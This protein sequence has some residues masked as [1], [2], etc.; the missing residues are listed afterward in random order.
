MKKRFAFLIALAA[1]LIFAMMVGER[2]ITSAEKPKGVT[3]SSAFQWSV[4]VDTLGITRDSTYATSG[5]GKIFYFRGLE[6][7][8][9]LNA[10]IYV[11]VTSLDTAGD[12]GVIDTSLDS[13]SVRIYAGHGDESWF[14]KIYEDSLITEGSAGDTLYISLSDSLGAADRVWFEFL[15]CTADRDTSVA[16]AEAKVNYKATV[17]MVA[18]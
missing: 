18:K 6:N 15:T 7:Y 4:G 13:M 14:R 9:T 8:S 10:A 2:D 11:V 16:E 1:I 3:Y 5:G 17:R 12:E